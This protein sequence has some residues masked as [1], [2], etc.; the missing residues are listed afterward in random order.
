VQ[1]VLATNWFVGFGGS[2][3]YLVTVAEELRALGHEPIIHA[4]ELGEMAEWARARGIRVASEGELPERCD[5]VLVQDGVTACSLAARYPGAPQL[6]V[7]HSLLFDLQA[8]PQVDGLVSRVVVLNDRLAS[9][10]RAMANEAEVVRLRQPVDLRRFIPRGDIRRTPK[11]ALLLS[12]NLTGLRRDVVLAACSELG[13][14]CEQTGLYGTPD[15]EPERLIA[16]A[17]IVIGSGRAILEGMAAGRATLLYDMR[18]GHGW[19][20]PDSYPAIEAD[21]FTGHR[22]GP[23]L[24]AAGLRTELAAYDPEMGL[25][26]R[27]LMIA[28]HSSRHHAVE[29][30]GQMR[31]IAPSGPRSPPSRCTRWRACRRCHGATRRRPT[32][33]SA[34][35]QSSVSESRSWRVRTGS[36]TSASRRCDLRAA[37]GSGHAREAGGPVASG[38]RRRVV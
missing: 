13:I 5:A 20:R 9:R 31:E 4:R 15:P 34:R 14:E 33:G 32:S 17:D 18:G 21:G 27:E 28:H 2:E 25:A 23:V 24:D 35:R 29:L 11:R 36:S 7:A 37:T 38:A 3:T 26:N 1:I 30:V 8:P 10:M 12:N 6:F 19:V 16:K 22:T